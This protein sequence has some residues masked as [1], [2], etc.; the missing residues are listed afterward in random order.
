M[1]LLVVGSVAIDSIETPFG[2]RPEVMGG[3]AAHF[4][5]AASFFTPVSLV[6]VVGEDYPKAYLE[7][8]RSRPIDLA[9]LQM[10]RGKTF[11]WSGRYKGS[12]ASAE[13]LA[14]ELNLFGSFD[15]VVPEAFRRSR[16]VFLANGSPHVQARVLEQVAPHP[17]RF[18]MLDTMNLWIATENRALREL[19][20]RVDALVLNDEELRQLTVE[21]NLVR[22]AHRA[23]DLGP[24]FVIVK[25]GEHG[26]LL[27]GGA[28]GAA[29]S[30]GATTPRIFVGPAYPID[31]VF[32]PTGAGDTFAGGLLG[33][34]AA[35]LAPD[36]GRSPTF[37]DLKRA[38]CVGIVTASFNVEDWGLDR[39]RRTT[40][41]EILERHARYV[42]MLRVEA[43]EVAPVAD[44][45]TPALRPAP[46]GP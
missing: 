7:I 10:R 28:T 31:L 18:V 26:A 8:L 19:L 43:P 17:S 21:A 30:A 4:S 33:S 38:V 9:G 27:L 32:D 6:G 3:S 22:A 36:E 20:P 12:M 29:G 2:T 23:L 39:L 44:A 15:P 11:R 16:F 37:G 1:S 40:R 34:L 24:R 46:A 42:D 41:E 14:V 45:A 13:T 5:Y 25:K 35:A